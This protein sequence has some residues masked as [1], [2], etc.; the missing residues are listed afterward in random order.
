VKIRG[1]IFDLDGTLVDVPYNWPRIK[2]DLNTGGQPI[3]KFLSDLP[4]PEKSRK[5]TVLEGY[6][7]IA[8]AKAVLKDGVPELLFYLEQRCIRT[9]LV[10]NNS[11]KNVSLL[12]RKFSLKFDI[13]LSRDSGMFKPT[14][15]PFLHILRMWNIPKAECGVVGDALFDVQAAEA[16]G[17]DRI[18]VISRDQSKFDG[19]KAEVLRSI[20]ELQDRISLLG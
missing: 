6:E 11:Q 14:A 2:A 7:K 13:T 15:Q 4:E 3:L 17:I 5:W 19:T 18:W 8:T 1:L 10:S 20:T 16:A 12:I 9:A